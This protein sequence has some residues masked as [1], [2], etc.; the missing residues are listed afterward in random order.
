[1]DVILFTIMLFVLE[2]ILYHI[3]DYVFPIKNKNNEKKN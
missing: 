1:M 2:Y 3:L